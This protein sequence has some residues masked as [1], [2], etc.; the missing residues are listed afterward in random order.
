MTKKAKPNPVEKVDDAGA[1][2]AVAEFVDDATALAQDPAKPAGTDVPDAPA[3]AQAQSDDDGTAPQA[4]AA[5]AV[6][7]RPATLGDI[8]RLRDARD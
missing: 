4:D 6:T 7:D 2:S 5:A 1:A 8:G 3:A